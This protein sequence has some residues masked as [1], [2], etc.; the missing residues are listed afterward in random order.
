MGRWWVVL[1]AIAAL[2]ALV[3]VMLRL[4]GRRPVDPSGDVVPSS[5]SDREEL[6]ETA[7]EESFPASDPPA[8]WGREVDEG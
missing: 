6:V 8:Y 2:A 3:V 1:G 4:L 7:L 5:G